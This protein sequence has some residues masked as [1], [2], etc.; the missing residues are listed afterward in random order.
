MR[1]SAMPQRRSASSSDVAALYPL[2]VLWGTT[3]AESNVG[4]VGHQARKSAPS[5]AAAARA[6]LKLLERISSYLELI[7]TRL[8]AGVRE[9][10]GS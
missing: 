7:L 6:Q 2:P 1:L 9:S 5:P 8:L 10:E 4:V 3:D